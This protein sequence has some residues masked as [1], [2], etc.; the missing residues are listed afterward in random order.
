VQ[1]K[2]CALCG[3]KQRVFLCCAGTRTHATSLHCGFTRL[4]VASCACV[5]VRDS[6]LLHVLH[7]MLPHPAAHIA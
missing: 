3:A 5:T 4:L 1:H 7:A 2:V 6:V